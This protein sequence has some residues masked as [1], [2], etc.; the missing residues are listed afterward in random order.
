MG[1]RRKGRELAV[2][3][4]YQWELSEEPVADVIESFAR[5][6][7]APTEAR[8]LSQRLLKGTIR[9][10]EEIDSLISKHAEHWKLPR[11]A[12]VDRNILRLAIYEFL[13]EED[14]PKRVVINE[15]LE[16]TKRF[17]GPE[18]VQF[19]NGVLDAVRLSIE[20]PEA[21]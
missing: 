4:L 16:V 12:A 2:Q 18:A 3:M 10:L 1:S 9:H 17:S 11:M 13:Y 7:D 21:R 15:A 8:E 5:L 19:I 14:V 6:G 20:A